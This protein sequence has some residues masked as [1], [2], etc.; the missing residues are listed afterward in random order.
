MHTSTCTCKQCLAAA[1][2]EWG[3][4][5]WMSPGAIPF[6]EAAFESPLS[7]LEELELALELLSV[8]SEAE[9]DQFLGKLFRGIGRGLRKVGRFIGRR[10]LPA[11]GKGLKS[12]A[13]AALPIAGKVLGSFI[14]IPGVGTALGGALGTAVSRALELEFR[15]LEAAEAELETAR[16]FIRI[17][18]TAAG[19]AAAAAPDRDAESVVHEALSNALQ[20]H[21][22]YLD[23]DPAGSHPRRATAARHGRWI[24]RGH[25]LI[26]LGA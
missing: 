12:L 7:E 24:R 10:V 16:R 15:D 17:A 21:L 1:N 6:G 20:Q 11:L 22:P 26:V 18:A 14:P 5:G 25:R 3:G 8:S 2:R 13:K 23:R 9:L 4:A 19:Q